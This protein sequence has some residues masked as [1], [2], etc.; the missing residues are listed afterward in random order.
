[1][2]NWKYKIDIKQHLIEEGYCFKDFATIANNVAKE[3]RK[4]PQWLFENEF[5]TL[6]DLEYLEGCHESDNEVYDDLEDYISEINYRING[7]YDF[8]DDNLIWCGGVVVNSVL[9]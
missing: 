7:L 5:S 4:L 8:A 1:M 2:A 3:F 9:N 6:D